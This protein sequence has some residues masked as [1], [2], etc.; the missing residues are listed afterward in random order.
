M[1][2]TNKAIERAQ[3]ELELDIRKFEVLEDNQEKIP[4]VM[5][6]GFQCAGLSEEE[7]KEAVSNATRADLIEAWTRDFGLD[8]I[9]KY[10]TPVES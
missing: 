6:I 7:A 3:K 10:S 1:K 5:Q 9:K 4:A 2:F 8:L